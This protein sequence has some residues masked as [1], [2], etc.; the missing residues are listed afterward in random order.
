MRAAFVESNPMP[1]KAAL[2]MMGRM[3][4]VVRLPLV[5]MADDARRQ[6]S[7]RRSSRR[8]RCS[9]R[10]FD[11]LEHRIEELA[12]TPAGEALAGR[13]ARRR[14]TRCSTRSKSGEVRVGERAARRDVAASTRG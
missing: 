9:E 5:P 11:E 8:E 3:Q 1:V 13:R 10:S 14:S 4:N 6:S 7:R 12:S 2:A